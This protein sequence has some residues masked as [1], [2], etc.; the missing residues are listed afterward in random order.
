MRQVGILAAAC[1]H[2][3]DHHIERLAEDHLR[4]RRLADGFR[5]APGVAVGEP[6][7]NIVIVTLEHESLDPDALVAALEAKGVRM[8]TFGGRRLRAIVHLDV[9]D[10]GIERAVSVFQD[11]VAGQLRTPASRN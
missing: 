3:L 1:L 5:A 6:D 11:V 2:A 7:T 9:D 4:A 8:M 10:A